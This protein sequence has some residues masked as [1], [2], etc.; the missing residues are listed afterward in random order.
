MSHNS[1]AC[2]SV[3]VNQG[4]T[5]NYVG[6]YVANHVEFALDILK[7]LKFNFPPYCYMYKEVTV[8]KA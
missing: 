5:E 3:C 2:M 1:H 8:L 6:P 4:C 7:F